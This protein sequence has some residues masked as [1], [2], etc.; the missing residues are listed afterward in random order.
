MFDIV[1]N[2]GSRLDPDIPTSS[3]KSCLHAKAGLGWAWA[4]FFCAR[5]EVWVLVSLLLG[6]AGV[7]AMLGMKQKLQRTGS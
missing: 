5:S 6:S 4:C 1:P 2:K 3:L 7:E